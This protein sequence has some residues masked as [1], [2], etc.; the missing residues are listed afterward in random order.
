MVLFGLCDGFR[1]RQ[2]GVGQV[3]G[4]LGNALGR[5]RT[6]GSQ[7]GQADQDGGNRR[8]P[9]HGRPS[10]VQ[11]SDERAGAGRPRPESI[12]RGMIRRFMNDQ[13]WGG[14]IVQSGS[15]LLLPLA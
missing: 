8:F 7:G 10:S 11:W 9:D 14:V 13:W 15:S 4:I 5:G 1:Q 6:M 2:L 3:D 12:L